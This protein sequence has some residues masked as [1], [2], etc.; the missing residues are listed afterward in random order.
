MT[1]YC[2]ILEAS[3]EATSECPAVEGVMVIGASATSAAEAM[4]G[5]TYPLITEGATSA[6]Q[7]TIDA[8][9]VLNGGATAA[10][11]LSHT[12]VVTG[13]VSDA[14]NATSSAVVGLVEVLEA[15]AQ[16]SAEIAAADV[17]VMLVSAAQATGSIVA[18]TIGVYEAGSDAV[19]ASS[20]TLGM[21]ELANSAAVSASMV[22]LLRRVNELVVSSGTGEA[23]AYPSN[24]PQDFLLISTASGSGLALVQGEH[25]LLIEADASANAGVWYTDPGRK[26]WVMNTET[27]AASWYDNFDFES[28]TQ[29][30]DGVLAVG[31]DGL[32]TLDANTDAGVNIQAEVV[33]G[34]QDFGAPQTKRMDYMY[35]GYTSGGRIS[36]TPEVYES[37]HA[38]VTYFLEQRDASA[39]R[40]SR[41]EPG[42]GLF[43]RYWRVTI[44]NVAGAD[45]EVH[46]TTVDIAVSNRKV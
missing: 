34:L 26:A 43:G 30:P 42:K 8:Y 2:E 23:T 35:F 14:A 19:A 29:T 3:A 28:I 24:I 21:A 41:V 33:S 46:D 25:N 9:A 16:A 10:S 6:S 11:T 4:V 36:V 38:P 1:E 20:V 13:L 27:T 40:N 7:V 37:G 18:N 5:R 32:Y 39:P 44:R 31:P 17:P 15:I 22:V 12:L 45:F